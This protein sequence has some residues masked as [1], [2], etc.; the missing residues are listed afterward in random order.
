MTG[1]YAGLAQ[2]TIS[3]AERIVT[4]PLV[5]VVMPFSG[6]PEFRDLRRSI[7]R[8]C[9]K[10]D[11]DAR[12]VDG[13]N[14]FKR[15][16]PEIMRQLRQSAF[17]IVD[18]TELKPNVFYEPGLADGLGKE[19]IVT[20]KEG[21]ELPFDINDIPVLFWEGFTDFEDAL[22]KRVQSIGKS[23]GR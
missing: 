12:A 3:L 22:E 15:I 11:F 21:T 6:E 13:T 4:T 18:V 9:K 20:A 14:Q 23:Q 16:I 1:D 7:E 2:S 5:F 17:V 8:V 10:Y 19:M